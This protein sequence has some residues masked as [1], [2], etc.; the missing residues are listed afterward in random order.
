MKAPSRQ[1]S[2]TVE[3]MNDGE[4]GTLCLIGEIMYLVDV[5]TDDKARRLG[6]GIGL[7]LG[8]GILLIIVIVAV[9]I[10]CCR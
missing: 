2:R 7:G 4:C 5:F 6:L 8:L 1:I 10:F 9:V 3:M